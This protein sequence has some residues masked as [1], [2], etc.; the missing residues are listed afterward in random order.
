MATKQRRKTKPRQ[1]IREDAN[2]HRQF[3]LHPED[4]D[5]FVRTGRQVIEGCQLGISVEVWLDECR[6]MFGR[7]LEWATARTGRVRA[8]Y[9]A[10]RMGGI[11][12]YFVPFGETYDFGLGDELSELNVELFRGFN[13]GMVEI[14]QVPATSLDRFLP[15]DATVLVY[16]D[17]SRSHNS[18]EA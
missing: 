12:L 3:V 10:P 16:G 9:A 2:G 18:V 15:P 14:H 8:C 7:V 5:A 11:T 17:A 13:V 1:H 6:A 4:N